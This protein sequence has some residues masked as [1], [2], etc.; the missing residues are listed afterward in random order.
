MNPDI[1]ITGGTGAMGSVLVRKLHEQGHRIRVLTVPG[2]PLTKRLEGM[3]VDIRYGDVADA[4]SLRG[5]GDG[6]SVVYH[7]AA[8]IITTDETLY[9]RINTEGTRN[10]VAE[11]VR[12]G[13]HHFI[14]VSSASVVYPQTTAY[15]RSKRAAERIVQESGLSYT[16]IRPTLVYG[17]RGGQEFDMFL[18]Y[19]KKFPVVPFIG[20]GQALKRPVYVGDIIGGLVKCANRGAGT[21][22]VY[23]FSGANAISIHDFARLCLVLMNREQVKIVHIPVWICRLMAGIMNR[24]FRDPPLKWSVIAGITQDANLDPQEAVR[25]LGYAPSGLID[26]LKGCFP[27]EL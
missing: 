22:K 18:A 10:M 11:A 7:L 23:N 8:I 20:K 9:T 21:G 13:V 5:I 16:I 17:E 19:L 3:D 27:R 24:M 15:S 14:H 1:L 4:E 26:T 12:A 2:D 6:I 25:E